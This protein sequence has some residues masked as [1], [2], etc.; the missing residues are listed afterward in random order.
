MVRV[1]CVKKGKLVNL[2][3]NQTKGDL[4]PCTI[5]WASLASYSPLWALVTSARTS[6]LLGSTSLWGSPPSP[7]KIQERGSYK[8]KSIRVEI[9]KI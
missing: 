3:K 4:C 8:Y 6:C 7:C 2:T 5:S 1:L 9:R